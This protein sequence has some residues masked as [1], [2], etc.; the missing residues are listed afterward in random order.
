M[1]ECKIGWA[2]FSMALSD[3]ANAIT[4]LSDHSLEKKLL[5]ISQLYTSQLIKLDVLVGDKRVSYISTVPEVNM[6]NI[7]IKNRRPL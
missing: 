7:L 4:Y 6:K 5:L 3:N 2:S 1:L